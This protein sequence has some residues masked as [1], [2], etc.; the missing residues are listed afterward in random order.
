MTIKYF[1]DVRHLT[2]CFEQRWN[3]AEPTL[4]ALLGDLTRQYGPAFEKRVLENG[5]LSSSITIFLNGQNAEL[6]SGLDTR[7]NPDDVVTV[8]PMVA[9]G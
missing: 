1:A 2:G 8:F 5:Q 7:L 3:K 4:G 9:G 6:L